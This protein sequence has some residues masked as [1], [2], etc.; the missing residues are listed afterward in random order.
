M[1]E[2]TILYN[3]VV[4]LAKRLGMPI[5]I[6][7]LESTTFRGQPNFGITELCSF[8]ISPNGQTSVVGG[9]VNPERAI[10]AKASEL[11]GITQSMVQDQATWGTLYADLFHDLA[12]ADRWVAGFN[13]ATFD[14]PAVLDMNRRYGRATTRFKQSF[15]VRTLHLKLSGAK[16]QTGTLLAVAAMYGVTPHGEAHRAQADVIVTVELLDAIIDRYGLDT[17]AQFIEANNQVAP[18]EASPAEVVAPTEASEAPSVSANPAPKKERGPR[19]TAVAPLIL[20]FVRDKSSVS[21]NMLATALGVEERTISFEV[22]RVIDDRVVNPRTFADGPAQAWLT[23]ELVEL[24][25][26]VLTQGKLKPIHEALVGHAPP[27][28][29]DYVQL[30]IALLTAGQSWNTLKPAH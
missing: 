26:D 23:Q 4:F 28:F 12:N 25:I 30:R 22:G 10:S 18:P 21:L 9:L 6:Y 11:T 7:D 14:N 27:E 17:V 3:N 8:T 24:D 15:D 5:T 1:F 20:D 13:N 29:L 16:T 2:E 19:K